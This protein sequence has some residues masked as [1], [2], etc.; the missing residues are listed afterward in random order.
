MK[1]IVFEQ[2]DDRNQFS[3]KDDGGTDY[4]FEYH[5]SIKGLWEDIDLSDFDVQLLIHPF[6]NKESNVFHCRPIL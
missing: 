4:C 2:T 1:D 6:L 3:F 5:P